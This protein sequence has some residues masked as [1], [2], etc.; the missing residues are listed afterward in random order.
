M[1]LRLHQSQ[2]NKTLHETY[3]GKVTCLE[4]F[5][6]LNA[7]LRFQ[8]EDCHTRFYG[9][10]SNVVGTDLGYRHQCFHSPADKLGYRKEIEYNATFTKKRI[11]SVQESYNELKDIYKV[12][13][14]LNIHSYYVRVLITTYGT[15][16]SN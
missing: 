12:A 7:N 1:S 14:K 11:A 13:D 4:K 9:K 15:S 8:C 5:T 16:T 2:F 6:T 10:C 3:N